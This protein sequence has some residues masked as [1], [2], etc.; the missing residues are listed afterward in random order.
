MARPSGAVLDLLLAGVPVKAGVITT[1]G[2][3]TTNG[4]T[5]VPF[6]LAGG[7]VIEVVAD[8]ACV[9]TVGGT[10]STTITNAAYGRPLAVGVPQRF[11]LRDTDTTIAVA[12]AGAT[13]VAVFVM[14]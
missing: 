1:A 2:A 5:A 7:S 4:T 11:C 12:G 13:N 9:L 14:R 6:T 8:A 3:S 10:A